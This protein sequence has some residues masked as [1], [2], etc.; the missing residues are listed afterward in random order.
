M[1]LAN[2]RDWVNQ[3]PASERSL[4]IVWKK[5]LLSPNDMIREVEHDTEI[6]KLIINAKLQSIGET[7][8]IQ[9]VIQG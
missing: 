3:L 2:L 9:Y 7:H 6:G 5:Y 4:R 8:G 1:V